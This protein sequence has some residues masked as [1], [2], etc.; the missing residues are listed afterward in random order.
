MRKHF[1]WYFKGFKHASELRKKLVLVKN[2]S[3]MKDI[4]SNIRH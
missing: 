3:E 1:G 4:L 2:Y